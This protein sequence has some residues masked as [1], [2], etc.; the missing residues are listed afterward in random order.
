[1][2]LRALLDGIN[3]EYDRT[4]GFD[5][6][7]QQLLKSAGQALT[8][9][10][11]SG[12]L[13][14]GSGG[15]GNPALIPWIAVFDPDET[16]TA[17]R[18]MYVVYL[19]AADGSRTYLTLNQGISELVERLGRRAGR[20]RLKA[21]A[22]AVRDSIDPRLRVG[23]DH[24]IDLRSK[25]ALAVGYQAGTILSR[26]YEMPDL[27]S[28]EVLVQD[29]RD[30][31]RLY[32][33]ALTTPEYLW[34]SVPD[35]MWPQNTPLGRVSLPAEFRPKSDGEY[36]QTVRAAVLRKARKH[37]TLVREY[38]EYAQD[39][40]FVAA[41]NV[42]PRDMTLERGGTHWLVEA[43]IVTHGSGTAAVREALGQLLY[44]RWFYYE[45]PRRVH[46]LGLFN[47]HISADAVAF[48]EGHGISAVWRHEGRW[49]GAPS[50]KAA[51]LCEL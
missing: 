26:T 21:Q 20:E 18:G 31:V 29:L 12:Y 49:I 32:Q 10:I 45:N 3:R 11:P 47:E 38:G 22:D 50:A 1:M 23:W 9:W 35:L 14:Q 41:T 8:R 28:E 48:L 42:H 24:G 34:V 17:R 16:T 7:A 37:E 43:K 33:A 36:E 46:M 13:A 27:P 44:Y 25:Q 40:G 15:K 30:V 39:Q 5:S 19:F 51:G 6:R 4:L 2:E